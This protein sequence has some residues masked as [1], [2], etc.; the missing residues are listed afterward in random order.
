M[1]ATSPYLQRPCRSLSELRQQLRGRRIMLLSAQ[2][3]FEAAGNKPA[4]AHCLR[5]IADIEAQLRG[6]DEAGEK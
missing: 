1:T 6:I 4:A 2:M 5:Q 3:E